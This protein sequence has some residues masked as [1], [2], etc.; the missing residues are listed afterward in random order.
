[1]KHPHVNE[2]TPSNP[3]PIFGN[4]YKGVPI[5]MAHY[6][7]KLV[8]NDLADM[9]KKIPKVLQASEAEKIG[10]QDVHEIEERRI[11][12]IRQRERQNK[13]DDEIERQK[14]II[15]IIIIIIIITMII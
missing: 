13:T 12:K 1:M 10:E 4:F 7:P 15:I 14:V 6:S 11:E 5:D 2:G 3:N 9:A 8:S